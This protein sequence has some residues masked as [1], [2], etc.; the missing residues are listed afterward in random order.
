MYRPPAFAEDDPAR[1][2]EILATAGLATLVSQIDGR[3]VADPLPMLHDPSRGRFGTLTC[4]LARANPQADPA[5]DGR[6]AL[7]IFSG[8]DAYVSPGWYPS[9]AETGRVVPTWNYVTVQAHGR[10][11]RF[12]DPDRL[13]TLVR[14]LTERHEAGRATS[15]AVDDAPADFIRAQLK[16]IVG[17]EIEIE[18]LEGKRKLSQNRTAADRAGVVAGLDASAAAEDRAV[19]AAMRA[20][21]TGRGRL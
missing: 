12:D 10:V 16:G 11:R 3:L 8:P 5:F 7:V 21:A 17:L 20:D 9:K 15:W 6:E 19:A 13:L 4:H 18:R 1:L 2:A 14:A